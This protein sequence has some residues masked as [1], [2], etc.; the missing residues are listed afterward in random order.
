MDNQKKSEILFKANYLIKELTGERDEIGNEKV[1][2]HPFIH[3]KNAIVRCEEFKGKRYIFFQKIGSVANDQEELIMPETDGN[4][5]L[6]A[7]SDPFSYVLYCNNASELKEHWRKLS[8]IDY[9]SLFQEVN[10]GG[11]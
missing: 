1:I 6:D 9:A 5:Y 2:Y 4:F 8:D 10:D 11:L 7:F 3:K